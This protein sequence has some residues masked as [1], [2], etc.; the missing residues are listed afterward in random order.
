MSQLSEC[1]LV[2]EVCRRVPHTFD[3]KAWDVVIGRIFFGRI[4]HKEAD[5]TGIF[6]EASDGDIQI[7]GGTWVFDA[8][9]KAQSE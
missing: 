7:V 1:E 2:F 5:A 8:I 4:V 6:L 3:V 9:F